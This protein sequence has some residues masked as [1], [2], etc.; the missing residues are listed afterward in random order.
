MKVFYWDKDSM[1]YTNQHQSS[2]LQFQKYYTECSPKIFLFSFYVWMWNLLNRKCSKCE[3]IEIQEGHK[4]CCKWSFSSL[5]W[6]PSFISHKMKWK[7]SILGLDRTFLKN[8]YP[9][10]ICIFFLFKNFFVCSIRLF[11]FHFFNLMY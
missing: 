10:L 8:V 4:Q 2:Q 11:L 9:S 3:F 6:R 1:I 5:K 7:K